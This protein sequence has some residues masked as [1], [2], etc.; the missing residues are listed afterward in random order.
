M[1]QSYV[2]NEAQPVTNQISRHL[3]VQSALE[4]LGSIFIVEVEDTIALQ[5]VSMS[6]YGPI[7]KRHRAFSS[8]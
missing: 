4:R 7:F 2:I 6:L 1:S 8:P 3:K 5:M